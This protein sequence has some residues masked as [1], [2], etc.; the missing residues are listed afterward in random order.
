MAKQKKSKKKDNQILKMLLLSL[1]ICVTVYAI[2]IVVSL[3]MNPTDTCIIEE[4]VIYAEESTVGYVIRDESLVKSKNENKTIEQIK[5]EGE[6]VAKGNPIFKYYNVNE[7]KINDEIKELDLEI[8]EALKGKSN[9]LP[10]DVKRIEEQINLKVTDIRKINNIQEIAEYKKDIENYIVKKAKIAGSLSKAGS[11]INGLIEKRAKLEN[12]LTKGTEYVNSPKSGIVSYRIDGLEEV[13]KYD[14]FSNLNISFLEN[15]DIKTGR[16]VTSSDKQ[17]K[18]VNNYG[19]YIAV[20]LDSEEAMNAEEG[21]SV[22][23]RLSN[24]EEVK[25]IIECIKEEKNERLIIFKIN[26]EVEKLVAYRKISVD[27]I[28]WKYEGLRVPSSAILYEDG[29]SYV[30]TNKNGNISKV[31]VKIARQ[32]NNYCIVESYE[33]E[34]LKKIGY[35]AEEINDIKTIKLYDEIIIN[36]KVE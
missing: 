1:I 14:N 13:L 27:V 24:D 3:I 36:P 35:T 21:N 30:V 22:K 8:Q 15:L 2:Y 32:N 26:K 9:L 28:W 34:E 17:A 16:I 20:I 19:C 12:D 10:S 33:T 23:I 7:S 6:K 5:K 18:I 11:Y 31:L 29:M 4:S 25:A